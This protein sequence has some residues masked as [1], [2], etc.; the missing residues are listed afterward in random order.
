MKINLFNDMNSKAIDNLER[1][2]IKTES[3][4]LQKL[5]IYCPSLLDKY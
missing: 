1:D 2:L 4:V 3:N 5:V